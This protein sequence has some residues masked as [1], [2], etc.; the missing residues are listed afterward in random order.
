MKVNPVWST[1]SSTNPT[2][3]PFAA[4]GPPDSFPKNEP[5][6]YQAPTLPGTPPVVPPAL[7]GT[8]LLPYSQ[9]YRESARV[10]RVADDSARTLPNNFAISPDQ[11]W[12]R[13]GPQVAGTRAILGLTDSPSA[14]RF[15]VQMARLSR[16]GDNSSSRRFIAAD[17]AGLSAGIAAMTSKT[18][19]AVREVDPLAAAPDAYP[20]TV[21]TYAALKPLSLDATARSEYASLLEYVGGDGQTPGLEPGRLP[22]G[23]APLPEALRNQTIEAAKTVRNLQPSTAPPVEETSFPTFPTSSYTTNTTV[24]PAADPVPVA[25]A[26]VTDDVPLVLTPVVALARNRFVVPAIAGLALFAALMALEITRRPRRIATPSG[27][28]S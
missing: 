26:T 7:C 24:P 21:L 19:R 8:E 20:L 3:I 18:E 15:G 22:Q 28:G 2:G 27:T 1:S 6:C 16:A 9:G 11:F 12:K 14:T 17:T 4:D 13:P 10:V 25:T 23:Y 5:Y